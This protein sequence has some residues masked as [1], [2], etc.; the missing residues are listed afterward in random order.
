[1]PRG[2]DPDA[3]AEF[4]SSLFEQYGVHSNAQELIDAHQASVD[5]ALTR[6]QL[7]QIDPEAT[8]EAKD[9]LDAAAGKLDLAEGDEVVDVAVRGNALVAVVQDAAGNTRKVVGPA[10]DKYKPPTLAPAEEQRRAEINRDQQVAAETRRL[11][12]EAD[13]KIAEARAAEDQR[14]SEEIA[15]IKEE[16]DKELA[17]K[18]EELE[19]DAESSDAPKRQKR[20]SPSSGE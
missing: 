5:P 19:S 7:A 12:A 10:N 3:A 16:K 6:A 9:D 17:S 20:S 1:M 18:V 14:V 8:A 2:N 15:K 13:A 4:D 11:R